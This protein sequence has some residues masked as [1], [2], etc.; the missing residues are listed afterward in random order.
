M[1]PTEG[2]PWWL[3]SKAA[4]SHGARHGATQFLL[5]IAQSPRAAVPPNGRSAF[6]SIQSKAIQEPKRKICAGTARQPTPCWLP[7]RQIVE[8]ALARTA[9]RPIA[10]QRARPQAKARAQRG[11]NVAHRL[12]TVAAAIVRDSVR[13]QP[14]ATGLTLRIDALHRPSRHVLHGFPLCEDGPLGGRA[15]GKLVGGFCFESLVVSSKNVLDIGVRFPHANF[16]LEAA[17]ATRTFATLVA[18]TFLQGAPYSR[19]FEPT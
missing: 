12:V 6:S 16:R 18:C 13:A 10:A 17:K 4:E 9:S 1:P 2:F 19:R 7:G 15:S 11:R 8:S 5:R 14:N 3:R